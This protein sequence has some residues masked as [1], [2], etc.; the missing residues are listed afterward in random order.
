[1]ARHNI[2][3]VERVVRRDDPLFVRSLQ[4]YDLTFRSELKRRPEDIAEMLE[5]CDT[6]LER[7]FIWLVATLSQTQDGHAVGPKVVTGFACLTVFDVDNRF[8]L[9]WVSYIV[10]AK[11]YRRRG[12]FAD[13]QLK[14][15]EIL[16]AE[17][18]DCDAIVFETER[19]DSRD[20]IEREE[21]RRRLRSFQKSGAFEFDM[22]YWQPKLQSGGE[23]VPLYLCYLPLKDKSVRR[24][25]RDFVAAVL[26][27]VYNDL[28]FSWWQLW[29]KSGRMTTQEV[30]AARD[31]HKALY[32]DVVAKLPDG[33]IGLKQEPTKRSPLPRWE[34]VACTFLAL[35]LSAAVGKAL[36]AGV[37]GTVLLF[38]AVVPVV[39]LIWKVISPEHYLRIVEKLLEV[40]HKL[41]GIP[42]SRQR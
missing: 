27:R 20:P 40:I 23:K 6:E 21:S 36:G 30:G 19:M 24:L 26:A 9:A 11:A 18:Y 39:L 15:Q 7:P 42:A 2:F 22:K 33:F 8:S 1:M 10:V 31:Y 41:A 3:D 29:G 17:P 35:I 14:I 34:L 4:I 38:I 5:I 37:T 32:E 16:T 25:P 13:L 12:V 28:Y